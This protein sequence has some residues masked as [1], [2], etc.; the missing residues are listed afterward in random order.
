MPGIEQLEGPKDPGLGT[1]EIGTGMPLVLPTNGFDQIPSD[2]I[3]IL[4][5]VRRE[6]DQSAAILRDLA[7]CL[8]REL[9]TLGTAE[10]KRALQSSLL[11]ATIA[12]QNEDRVQQR[13]RDL[14]EV[15]STLENILSKNTVSS[16][17]DINRAVIESLRLE[18]MRRAFAIGAGFVDDLPQSLGATKPPSI[19]EV[20]L[21]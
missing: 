1:E 19:G 14:G 4:A 6:M 13:L 8:S 18:E 10:E 11:A 3:P 12:L 21:F 2:L 15:L 7:G 9:C 5:V 17:S 20:D 16:S